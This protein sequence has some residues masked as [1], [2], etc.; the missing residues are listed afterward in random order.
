MAGVHCFMTNLTDALHQCVG[1][2]FISLDPLSRFHE[3]TV[4]DP[5]QGESGQDSRRV[6]VKI[7][8]LVPN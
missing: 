6:P 4:L 3:W 7:R 5:Y 1:M 8:D 2:Y